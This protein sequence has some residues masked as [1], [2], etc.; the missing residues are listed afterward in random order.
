MNK[1][2]SEG[3]TGV[4]AGKR[5]GIFGKGGSGKSTVVVLL[6]KALQDLGYRVC[7]LDADSTNVGLS[8]ALG[9]DPP[10][11]TL[12]DYYGGMVF[13]G[14]SVTCPVDDPTPLEG[15]D[16]SLDALPSQYYTQNQAGITLLSAGKIGDLGPGAGC[17]GPISKVARDV[18]IQQAE[19][20][21]VTLVDFKAGFEDSARGVITGLDWAIVVVDPTVAAVEMAANMKD[22]VKQIKAG[23]M[24]AT[25]HLEDPALV[26]WANKIFKQAEIK[27]VLFVM[28]RVLDKE[29]EDYLRN[30]LAQ[31]G[32]EPIAV[33]GDHSSISMSWLKGSPIEATELQDETRRMAEK[34]E[35]AEAAYSSLI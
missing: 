14:G 9:V 25:E 18:R 10:E 11:Q 23:G 5:V 13:S 21:P 12:I 15:A 30:S 8:Q 28:N 35:A 27:D 32:I 29:M 16:I 26:A 4:L 20:T 33:I 2:N 6:A 3:K 17:D 24:P 1:N 34:L 19:Y 7:V 31:V 22:M